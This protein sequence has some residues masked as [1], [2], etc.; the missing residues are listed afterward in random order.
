MNMTT[1]EITVRALIEMLKA[2]A[3]ATKMLRKNRIGMSISKL[4]VVRED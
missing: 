2:L 1:K 4:I 3:L